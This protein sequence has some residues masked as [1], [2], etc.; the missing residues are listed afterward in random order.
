M[1]YSSKTIQTII[2]GISLVV[3]CEMMGHAT[4]RYYSTIILGMFG[5]CSKYQQN[6]AVIILNHLRVFYVTI[7]YLK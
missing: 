2:L 6:M 7:I 4:V 1:F 3:L 5:V